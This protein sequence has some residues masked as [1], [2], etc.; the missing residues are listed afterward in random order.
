MR[1][2]YAIIL[3]ES[4]IL[5]RRWANLALSYALS[6]LLFMITFGW[7]ARIQDIGGVSYLAF[8]IPGLIASNGMRHGFS[9]SSEINIARFY[10]HV[11]DA[12]R[13]TPIS[14]LAYACGEVIS[15]VVRGLL[16]AL[17][18]V[19]IALVFGVAVPINGLLVLSVVCNAFVF[20]SLAVVTSMIVKT[21]AQQ[22][23]LTNFVITPMS[24]LCGT[25]FPVEHYP[26]W[27][28]TWVRLLPLT[29]AALTIRA[30]ALRQP[31]PVGSLV[32][33]VAFGAACF[34]GAV[35]IV[36]ASRD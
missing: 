8:M 2:L 25:F 30:A 20:A 14:D 33:L 24:F 3:R 1:A 17:F 11:F 31:F 29:H 28:Q 23:M 4:I 5:K 16:G 27:V 12:I 6:P 22:A 35:Y 7:A 15:G 34:I 18:I 9:L 13:S 10:W 36:R 21:H 19:A 26:A 32:Y